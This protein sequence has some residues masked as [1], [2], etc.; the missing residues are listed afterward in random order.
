METYAYVIFGR[1]IDTDITGVEIN[2][3]E[4]LR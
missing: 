4:Y 1:I 3:V 2:G